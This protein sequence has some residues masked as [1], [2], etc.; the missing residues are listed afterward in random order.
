MPPL[1]FDF[2]QGI[3]TKFKKLSGEKLKKIHWGQLCFHWG[4]KQ[5]SQNNYL[6]QL[7]YQL[8]LKDA[9]ILESMFLFFSLISFPYFSGKILMF[10][11]FS[12]N[13]L[14]VV[15]MR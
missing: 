6:Y 1:P 10:F 12:V 15:A 11:G 13:A 7:N 9:E 4:A 14:R 3:K 8:C 2:A 5:I